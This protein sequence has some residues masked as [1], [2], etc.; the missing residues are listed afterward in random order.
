[1]PRAP[2]PALLRG[3]EDEKEV[4]RHFRNVRPGVPGQL[5]KHRHMAVVTAGVHLAGMV[6]GVAAHHDLLDGQRVHV[7]AEGGGL[8]LSRVEIGQNA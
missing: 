2:P 5:Q 3:L 1:M 4:S 7:G 6:G 8:R